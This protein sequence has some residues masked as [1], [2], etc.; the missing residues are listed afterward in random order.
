MGGL[1]GVTFSM[2]E[3]CERFLPASLLSVMPA[4]KSPNCIAKRDLR[5]Y[6]LHLPLVNKELD[7]ERSELAP[8]QGLAVVLLVEQCCPAS[9]RRSNASEGSSVPSSRN[10]ALILGCIFLFR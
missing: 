6:L 3:D 5:D 9:F 10:T 8:S 1:T 2:L 4:S 7:S